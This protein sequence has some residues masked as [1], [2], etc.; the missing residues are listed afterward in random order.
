MAYKMKGSPAK[1][2]KIQGTSGHSSALKQAKTPKEIS[3]MSENEMRMHLDDQYIKSTAGQKDTNK[4]VGD[5]K[6]KWGFD[7]MQ[8]LDSFLTSGGGKGGLLKAAG[9][10]LRSPNERLAAQKARE[11]RK[12]KNK[13]TVQERASEKFIKED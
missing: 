6:S 2:G 5:K 12:E 4:E 8:L 13:Q 3:K 10:A 7:F 1:L 9:A 11:A